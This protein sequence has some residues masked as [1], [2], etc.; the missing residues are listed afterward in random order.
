MH[1]PAVERGLVR[2]HEHAPVGDDRVESVPVRRALDLIALG[3][4]ALH[5]LHGHAHVDESRVD[6]VD[7]EER[8]RLR[9][10]VEVSRDLGQEEPRVLR[11]DGHQLCQGCALDD[12]RTPAAAR[13]MVDDASRLVAFDRVPDRALANHRPEG[14]VAVGDL[15]R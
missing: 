8:R 13:R 15:V 1:H 10:Q 2:K 7:R 6:R 11:D 4:G 5:H 12:A 14:R 9:A 3:R